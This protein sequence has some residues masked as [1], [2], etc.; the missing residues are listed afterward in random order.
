MPNFFYIAKSLEGQTKSGTLPAK[1][2]RELAQKL[3]TEGLILIKASLEEEK[4]KKGFEFSLSAFGGIPLTEKMMF[5]RN[6]RVM[7][8]AGLPLPRAL[9]ILG[10]QTPFPKFKTALH[11]IAEDIV[12]GTS[13]SKALA[14]HP[15]VFP[16]IFQS[17]VKVGEEGG[18]LEQVLRILTQQMEREHEVKSKIKGALIYPTVII[19]AMICIG[20]LMLVVVVPKLAETFE[21]LNVELPPA[22]KFVIAVGTFL[23]NYWYLLPVIVLFLLILIKIILT[24]PAGKRVIDALTLKIPI[25][26]PIIK[27]T[28]SAYTVRTLGSLITSGVPIVRSLEVTSG[29]LGNV[30]YKEALTESAEQVRKGAKLSEILK[31]YQNLYPTLVIQMVEVGEETGQTSEI[32]AQLANFFEEEVTNATKNITAI[33]E[34]VIML[35]IGAA[36]GF[37]AISMIQPM[38]S[39]LGAIH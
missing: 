9:R 24:A 30:Y 35:V 11:E 33:I 31:S 20:I 37:F 16:E 26:A 23:A 6:L 19:I 10:D 18:T 3:K 32:L 13:F 8:A 12:R 34:P 39:M 38:Y 25:I 21:E 29:A 36:V 2:T 1:D 14:K 22:T 17:M 5:A 15:D 4:E 7:I 28:N 27:K